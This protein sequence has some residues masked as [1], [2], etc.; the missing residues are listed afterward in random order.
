MYFFFVFF[1]D[2]A[3]RI[4]DKVSPEKFLWLNR[5]SDEIISLSSLLNNKQLT[6]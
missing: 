4:Q 6:H 3:S 1:K 2:V 5:M